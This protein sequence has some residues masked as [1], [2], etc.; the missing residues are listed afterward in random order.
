[1]KTE[2]KHFMKLIKL[3]LLS[4]ALTGSATG[5]TVADQ[6]RHFVDSCDPTVI[7]AANPRLYEA[8]M[9]GWMPPKSY[10]DAGLIECA[11]NMNFDPNTN[12]VLIK[13]LQTRLAT[14]QLYSGAIDGRQS[15]LLK[16]VLRRFQK[17]AG[18]EPTGTLNSATAA[19]LAGKP[20]SN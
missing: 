12:V 13:L 4:L 9:D 20:L 17:Q 2:Q 18:L 10:Q 15:R 19:E 1:M 16:T 8:M 6:S 7:M 3:T 14:L 5:A 11:L